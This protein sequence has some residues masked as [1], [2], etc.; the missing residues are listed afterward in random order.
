MKK[1]LS[2]AGILFF[3]LIGVVVVPASDWK[4]ELKQK[5]KGMVT[6]V[7]TAGLGGSDRNRVKEPGTVLVIQKDGI[8]G[9]KANDFTTTD[10]KVRDGKVI[11]AGGFLNKQNQ[12]AFKPGE[13]VYVFQID[14][15]DN[16][17]WYWILSTETFSITEEGSTQQTRYKG[18]IKFQF[19]K[20]YLATADFAK[21][22]EAIDAVLVTEDVAKAANTKTIELGQTTEQVETILGKPEKI[23]KLGAKVVYVYKDMKVIFTDGKVSDVQ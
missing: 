12:H 5:L 19:P 20:D 3:L 8:T 21:V 2:I 13:R 11:Q 17:I 6:L 18:L 15:K 23:I 7:K 22:K 10:T 16:E 4:D 14:V 9:D 1:L